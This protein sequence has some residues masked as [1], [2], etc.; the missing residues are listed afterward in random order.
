MK[1]LMRYIP[2]VLIVTAMVASCQP[3][4]PVMT[5]PS[6][7]EETAEI[8]PSVLYPDYIDEFTGPLPV[9]DMPSL[10]LTGWDWGG[11]T[12]DVLGM[13][14]GILT[15]VG[16]S[17]TITQLRQA[18]D[19]L[20]KALNLCDDLQKQ[21]AKMDSD[22][23]RMCDTLDVY[24][25]RIDKKIIDQ[26]YRL[27]L[28]T[29]R[30]RLQSYIMILNQQQQ[31][32]AFFRN[33]VF[34][35]KA[36][37]DVIKLY[38]DLYGIVNTP[39]SD[40]DADM[41]RKMN[42]A[43]AAYAN[44][45]Y[46]ELYTWMGTDNARYTAMMSYMDWAM[47]AADGIC[48]Y[49]V[50]GVVDNIAR[51]QAAWEHETHP[52]RAGAYINEM[53]RVTYTGIIMLTFLTGCEMT[54]RATPNPYADPAAM[55]KQLKDKLLT[56]I[57]FI[58]AHQKAIANRPERICLIGGMHCVVDSVIYK[59]DYTA[60]RSWIGSDCTA[61]QLIYGLDEN[62]PTATM[63][64]RQFTSNEVETFVQFYHM[65]NKDNFIDSVL[66]GRGKLMYK[67]KTHAKNPYLLL[68]GPATK[69]Q[70][71]T[72]YQVS[73]TAVGTPADKS[74]NYVVDMGKLTWQNKNFTG[75]STEAKSCYR[76]NIY[77]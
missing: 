9:G 5:Y 73:C 70:L 27:K 31:R 53:N 37:Q 58:K 48:N 52:F 19:T 11:I 18:R 67:D 34:A 16:E 26:T 35:E 69:K 12:G 51:E 45:H 21:L 29:K 44:A 41:E 60:Q 14:A 17:M 47:S 3:N 68:D 56:Y 30:Q 4:A 77:R 23:L 49:D 71:K 63:R 39:G 28:Y 72:Q 36:Y 2:I 20:V 59:V 74:K 10:T 33:D 66:V 57:E 46:E 15:I 55:R 13:G 40:S 43:M 64:Y 1:T 38:T 75:W 25:G 6:V 61:D 50:L 62:I 8:Q 7:Q 24:F 54:H 65:G 22:I 42:E 76:L 32:N